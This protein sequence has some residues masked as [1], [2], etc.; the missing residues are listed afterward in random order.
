MSLGC[1]LFRGNE[2]SLKWISLR[3]YPA[4][5][6]GGSTILSESQISTVIIQI[7]EINVCFFAAMLQWRNCSV[8]PRG[9]T[10]GTS[11][12]S[13]RWSSSAEVP[14]ETRKRT[15]NY[16]YRC[17]PA[18]VDIDK[19]KER[20][21]RKG[22]K[23]SIDKEFLSIPALKRSFIFSKSN[24]R[25]IWKIDPGRANHPLGLRLLIRTPF[26]RAIYKISLVIAGS[27]RVERKKINDT[28]RGLVSNGTHGRNTGLGRA[29]RP[30]REG[31]RRRGRSNELHAM[32]LIGVEVQLAKLRST[33]GRYT[34]C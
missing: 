14:P 34:E 22:N 8:W 12:W 31:I 32:I 17:V 27:A 23:R 19:T 15:G 28:E 1:L 11:I 18:I 26:S 13:A 24:L 9:E 20:D 5:F 2:L 16:R 25:V 21:R 30:F 29:A 33:L 3:R 7:H 10:A 6:S 4:N